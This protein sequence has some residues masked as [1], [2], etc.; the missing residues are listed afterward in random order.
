M[1]LSWFDFRQFERRQSSRCVFVPVVETSPP[2]GFSYE[3]KVN[4]EYSANVERLEVALFFLL[5][6]VH[7]EG[8][9]KQVWK[10][11]LHCADEIYLFPLICVKERH[12]HEKFWANSQIFLQSCQS[13]PRLLPPPQL[14]FIS[15]F[16]RKESKLMDRGYYAS[17]SW[18]SSGHSLP[19]S[20]PSFC[21]STSVKCSISPHIL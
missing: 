13:A 18:I 20:H 12:S 10:R 16:M 2:Q 5:Q 3:A 7:C 15:S 14:C 11:V 6:N 19:S 9:A 4:G 17:I 21:R 8:G 1:C